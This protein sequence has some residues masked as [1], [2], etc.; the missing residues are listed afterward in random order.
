MVAGSSFFSFNSS[1]SAGVAKSPSLQHH[2]LLLLASQIWFLKKFNFDLWFTEPGLSLL[3]RA[4]KSICALHCLNGSQVHA[5]D[6]VWNPNK[7]NV[8]VTKARKKDAN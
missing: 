3:M 6:A 2:T 8:L 5:G 7:S 1:N 4:T